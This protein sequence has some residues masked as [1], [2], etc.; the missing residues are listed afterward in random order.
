MFTGADRTVLLVEDEALIALNE[1]RTLEKNGLGVITVG[2]GVAAVQAITENAAI[3]LVLMDIDLGPG[4][5][6][7]EAAQRILDIRDVPIVFLSS[8]AEMDTRKRIR[9][10]TRYGYV[11]KSA[12]EIVLLEAIAT[13]FELYDAHVAAKRNFHRY[14]GLFEGAINPITIYN[15]RAE[16]VDINRVAA[17]GIGETRESAIGRPLRD[18]VPDMHDETVRRIELCLDGRRLLEFED[19]I[20]LPSGAVGWYRSL[21]QPVPGTAGAD[22]LCQIISYHITQQKE[23]EQRLLERN[24][25]YRLIVETMSDLIVVTDADGIVAFATGNSRSVSGY[26]RDDLVGTALIQRIH[27]GDRT[28]ARAFL[29]EIVRTRDTQRLECRIAHRNGGYVWTE[30]TGNLVDEA[31]AGSEI[32]IG[33]RDYSVQR[34]TETA[35]RER[36]QQLAMAIDGANIAIYDWDVTSGRID[37]N[38]RWATML[39]FTRDEVAAT[40]A[41]W[42][43]LLH[44]DDRPAAI[45]AVEALLE[46]ESDLFE[47]EHR[48]RC[49]D[50]SWRWVLN[51]GRT[52]YRDDAGN[53]VRMTGVHI[54][55]HDRRVA[56]DDLR[57]AVVE[58]DDLMRELNHRVKNNLMMI[59][60]LISVKQDELGDTADLS[61]IKRRLAAIQA[62]YQQ[63]SDRTAHLHVSLRAYLDDLL[64]RFFEETIDKR[65]VWSVDVPDLAIES[66]FGVTFG[67]ITNEIAVNAV[68]HAFADTPA[69]TFNVSLTRN[70]ET[71]RPWILRLSNNGSPIPARIRFDTVESVGMRLVAALVEQIHGTIRIERTNGTTVR[72]A[73]PEEVLCGSSF[74]PDRADASEGGRRV[75]PDSR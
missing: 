1:A 8:H 40:E 45:A 51:R 55:I 72:I 5:D 50:G 18:F 16:I 59:S 57:R 69:P 33:I 7:T 30:V 36:E 67:L 10:I 41:G 32:V 38:D 4:I 71:D 74:P 17:D 12:G 60:S 15:R 34:R 62:I 2:T 9:A 3:D 31:R 73:I 49:R 37:F 58:K 44:P 25:H 27:P 22:A 28:A 13:A 61:D 47:V 56:E 75:D 39:G 29:R 68:K 65:V 43:A 24:R 53:P 26:D 20:T 70:G 6:G 11:L 48:M 42:E 14:I 54:D 64:E 66:R 19:R 21:I 52:V 63:L 46:G 35:L 23:T